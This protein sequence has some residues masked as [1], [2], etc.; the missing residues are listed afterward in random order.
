MRLLL[1]LAL[2]LLAGCASPVVTQPAA[3]PSPTPSRTPEPVASVVSGPAPSAAFPS[4]DCDAP[5]AKQLDFWLGTWDVAWQGSAGPLTGTNTIT[6]QGC[7][8]IEHFDGPLGAAGYIGNSASAWVP[9]LRKWVQHYRDTSGFVASYVGGVE[10]R[11]FILYRA[12]PN[13]AIANIA[14]LVWRD[15]TPDR[16]VWTNDRTP[17]DG[18]TWVPSL[19]I[20]YA[21][22][23]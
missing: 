12:T 18:A 13:L 2:A 17:D 22:R 7:V 8:V 6:K 20:I 14:R 10:G 16:M 19:T 23:R 9:S 5:E 4:Q 15:I 21:R 3:S 1:A 11:A